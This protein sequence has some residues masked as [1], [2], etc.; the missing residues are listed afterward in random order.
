MEGEI[1]KRII[2]ESVNFQDM[3]TLEPVI[4]RTQRQPCFVFAAHVFVA[5]VFATGVFA[6]DVFAAVAFAAVP[7]AACVFVARVYMDGP[8]CQLLGRQQ[9]L[10]AKTLAAKTKYDEIK[11]LSSFWTA[12]GIKNSKFVK[13]D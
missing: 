11:I 2:I 13:N 12:S 1:A 5:H 4:C 8:R 9:M 6:A 3:D 7:F 10:A